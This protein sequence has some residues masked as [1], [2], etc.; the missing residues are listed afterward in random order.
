M[1]FRTRILCALGAVG[2]VPLSLAASFSFAASKTELERTV[3]RAQAAAAAEAARGCERFIARALESLRISTGMLP[4]RELTRDELAKVLGIPYRQLD[5]V[6]ALALLDYDGA[7][8]AP[9]VVGPFI[10]GTGDPAHVQRFLAHVPLRLAI[11]AGTAIGSAYRDDGESLI[12]VA[13]QVRGERSVVAAE[14]SLG[15]IEQR[16]RQ[17]A[18]DD[19]ARVVDGLGEVLAGSTTTPLSAAERDLVAAA[20]AGRPISRVVAGANGTR[21]LASAAAVPQIG[22]TV[23]VA[24]P[25]DEA[26]RPAHHVRFY[27]ALWAAVA[28]LL[29]AVLGVVLSRG[30]TG[31]ME[32][33][34][35][36]VA[37]LG[38]GRYDVDLDIERGDEIGRFADAFRRM[39]GDLRRRDDE[40]RRWNAELQARV[41]QGTRELRTAQDQILRTRRLAALGSLGAG[42]AH[43]LNNPLTAV[44]GLLTLLRLDLQPDSPQAATI[45]QA[46]DQSFRMAKIVSELRAFAEQERGEGRT[47]PLDRPVRAALDHY[48]GQL[49]RQNIRVVTDLAA[50][51]R[52][53]QGDPARIQ[54]AVANVVENAI[55]AM[56]QGGELK[57]EL[58][59]VDGEALKLSISDTGEGIPAALRE[60]IFDPFFTTKKNGA[61]VG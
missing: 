29:I 10:S 11:D 23:L 15:E 54:R 55:Q 28:L 1:S 61:G 37:Q 34:S 32:K 18:G 24:Q 56:P 60:R 12:A 45:Q 25:T 19:V 14:V 43:E 8:L 38:D 13:L 30:L 9:P 51:S 47:F 59:D 39:A 6:R 3:G 16:M 50:S 27:S 48:A 33:L 17:L 46:L 4:L 5:F 21:W 44:T 31:P 58:T 49:A 41:D 26:F 2:L 36:A 42:I 20:A 22:W 7:L 53:T 52:Q 40:I 57:V 35:Q